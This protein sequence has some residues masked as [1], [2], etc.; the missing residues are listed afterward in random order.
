MVLQV[1]AVAL[2]H[3]IPLAYCILHQPPSNQNILS[4]YRR[5]LPLWD[6]SK[7]EHLE[8]LL[9]LLHSSKYARAH[10]QSRVRYSGEQPIDVS[11]ITWW[12]PQPPPLSSGQTAADWRLPEFPRPPHCARIEAGE[13]GKLNV[14]FLRQ[15]NNPCTFM[16]RDWGLPA[17][18]WELPAAPQAVASAA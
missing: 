13:A 17:T 14:D 8:C 16:L 11:W 5:V 2:W 15:A 10:Q 6:M 18:L 12:Y 1:C 7:F 4:L 3:L 9:L